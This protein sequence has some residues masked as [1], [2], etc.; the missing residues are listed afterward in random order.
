MRDLEISR[1][2]RNCEV[3]GCI[4]KALHALIGARR[5]GVHDCSI[6]REVVQRC[7]EGERVG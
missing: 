6:D 2:G 1:E 3:M 5:R 7:R 4:Q